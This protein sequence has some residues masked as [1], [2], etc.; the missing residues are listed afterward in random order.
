MAVFNRFQL[1]P[2]GSTVR[3]ACSE[4]NPGTVE[5]YRARSKHLTGH[6]TSLRAGD[7]PGQQVPV[8]GRSQVPDPLGF[9]SFEQ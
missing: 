9:N 5:I 2:L 7:R 8:T 6:L 1:R 3:A 4:D